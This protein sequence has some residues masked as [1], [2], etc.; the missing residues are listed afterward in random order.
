MRLFCCSYKI[1]KWRGRIDS[2]VVGRGE[3]KRKAEEEKGRPNGVSRKE[4]EEQK[5]RGE[6]RAHK[7]AR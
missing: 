6:L 2:V 3:Q 4:G 1:S 5:G 7:K